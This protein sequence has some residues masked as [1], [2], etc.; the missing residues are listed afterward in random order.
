MF[1]T[2]NKIKE[3][4]GMDS[5]T[6]YTIIV[7]LI[8]FIVPVFSKIIKSDDDN[9]WRIQVK[10]ESDLFFAYVMAFSFLEVLFSCYFCFKIHKFF[11]SFLENDWRFVLALV[12][13][14]ISTYA[15]WKIHFKTFFIRKRLIG[16]S[17]FSRV[18]CFIPVFLLNLVMWIF[19][20]KII[21]ALINNVIGISFIIIEITGLLYFTGRYITY[22]YSYANIYAANGNALKGID[23][24]KIKIKG[25]WIIIENIQNETRIKLIELQGIEYYGEQKVKLVNNFGE[26]G[27]KRIKKLYRRGNKL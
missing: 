21:N 13:F 26:F 19:Y 4:T 11:L 17:V 15:L 1:S 12:L 23:I 22:K 24:D 6:T 7:S 3:I 25:K 2:I 9:R 18:L 20:L 10:I 14:I 16:N 27:F 5:N 8:L